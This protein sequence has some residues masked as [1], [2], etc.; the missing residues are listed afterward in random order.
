[1]LVKKNGTTSSAGEKKQSH[2]PCYLG[3]A[4]RFG[5]SGLL[6]RLPAC[7]PPQ[8]DHRRDMLEDFLAQCHRKGPATSSEPVGTQET[9]QVNYR[10]LLSHVTSWEPLSVA[11]SRRLKEQ[12]PLTVLSPG[13]VT[14]DMPA[15]YGMNGSCSSGVR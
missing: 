15:V 9:P 4:V 14:G 5:P 3:R 7:M 8:R 11:S 12:D 6:T 10:W 13:C 2:R 1:M